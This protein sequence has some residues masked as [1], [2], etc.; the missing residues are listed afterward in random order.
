M[1]DHAGFL[2]EAG[3][4][5]LMLDMRAH[6]ESSGDRRM[7]GWPDTVD[8]AAQVDFLTGQPDIEHIGIIGFSTGAQ[9]AARA[10]ADLSQ[11]EAIVLD[12]PS[13][14]TGGDVRPLTDDHALFVFWYVTYSL[15]DQALA[16]TLDIDVPEAVVDAL[17]RIEDRPV[18][19]IAGAKER[20]EPDYGKAYREALGD[21]GELWLIDGATHGTTWYV[22]PEYGERVIAFFD[23]AFAG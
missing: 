18:L 10:A 3:Y 23:A 15:I 13:P 22:A 17:A 4:G 7:S 8:V 1:G 16:L 14:A 12:G 5:V 9:V 11:I 2:N 21:N 19:V 20:P 6:G